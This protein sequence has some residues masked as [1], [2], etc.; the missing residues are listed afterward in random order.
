MK[1][2]YKNAHNMQKIKEQLNSQ[3]QFCDQRNGKL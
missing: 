1:G 2:S 3:T